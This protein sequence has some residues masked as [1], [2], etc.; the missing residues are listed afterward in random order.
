[1]YWSTSKEAL[2]PIGI[3][4]PNLLRGP[5]GRYLVRPG[6]ETLHLLFGIFAAQPF[7]RFPAGIQVADVV[8]IPGNKPQLNR[9]YAITERS[10][11]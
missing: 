5:L 4:A 10:F 8:S 3:A 6:A 11:K 9:R 1:V 2:L 7:P